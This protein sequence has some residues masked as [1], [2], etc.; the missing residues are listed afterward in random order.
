MLPRR[1]GSA[2]PTT[3]GMSMVI[4]MDLW[5]LGTI[6]YELL[7]LDMFAS[8]REDVGCGCVQVG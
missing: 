8:G 1:L 5:S 4:L 7:T 3:A 2:A 6:I